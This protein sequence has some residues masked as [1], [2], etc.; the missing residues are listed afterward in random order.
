MGYQHGG[1]HYQYPEAIDFSAN[2]NPFGMPEAVKRAAYQGIADAIYYPDTKCELLRQKIA[3][4]ENREA[5]ISDINYKNIL[6]GNGAA[7]LIYQICH[8]IKPLRAILAVPT[9]Q[10]YEQALV[11]EQCEVNYYELKEADN[12]QVNESFLNC[13]DNN[14]DV[15]FLCNPNNPTGQL[16]KKDILLRILEYCEKN[17]ILLVMDECFMDF[18]IDRLSLIDKIARYQQLFII[19]AFTKLYAMPGLRLGYGVSSNRKLL[20][21]ITENSQ[22]WNISTPAQYAGIAALSQETYV[23]KSIIGIASERMYLLQEIRSNQLVEHVV[24]PTAN[25]IFFKAEERLGKALLKKGIILRD[26]SNY[27]N[28]NKGYYRMAIR[29]HEE[30]MLLIKAW[31]ECVQEW[32]K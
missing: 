14:M 28:L 19:K 12:Y 23:K 18:C 30:N 17:Q 26:C 11:S 9:F 15:I 32:Q 10:E 2:L 13:L 7:D 3:E 20:Q 27:R 24:P 25:Y 21:T 6:L 16:I 4:Y 31:K 8:A 1:M 22:P 29:L 5:G